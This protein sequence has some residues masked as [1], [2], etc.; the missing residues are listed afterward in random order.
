[1]INIGMSTLTLP[2]TCPINGVHL[3]SAPDE[4]DLRLTLQQSSFTV[5]RDAEPL[6]DHSQ[7]NSF[8]RRITIPSESKAAIRMD[9]KALGFR[10][11]MLFPDLANLAEC[12]KTDYE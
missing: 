7:A 11:S 5:H 12:L 1:M 3:A 10:R 8:L 4:V 2:L 9:L 6:E